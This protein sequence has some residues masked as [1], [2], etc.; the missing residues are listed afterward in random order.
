L[1]PQPLF[2]C[3]ICIGIQVF[4]QP[5][6]IELDPF[7]YSTNDASVEQFGFEKTEFAGGHGFLFVEGVWIEPPYVIERRGLDVFVNDVC[8]HAGS[9]LPF[10]DLRVTEDP[11]PPPD[12][13]PPW[14]PWV[15]R[16]AY[17]HECYWS[18]KSR[19]LMG[20]LTEKEFPEAMKAAYLAS[21]FVVSVSYSP[22]RQMYE[23]FPEEGRTRKIIQRYLPPPPP[24]ESRSYLKA[25][26]EYQEMQGIASVMVPVLHMRSKSGGILKSS[27]ES[28]LERLAVLAVDVEPEERLKLL[29]EKTGRKEL[30]YGMINTWTME[31]KPTEAFRVRVQAAEQAYLDH[32]SQKETQAKEQR[33]IKREQRIA[34]RQEAKEARH[35]ELLEAPPPVPPPVPEDPTSVRSPTN[36]SLYVLLSA[37]L[38]LLAVGGLIF[39]RTA[40]KERG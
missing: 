24:M 1:R 9:I 25:M 32:K 40:K 36:M 23:L 29:S 34:E 35:K 26:E 19:Y 7:N 39:F 15:G 28:A 5:A 22:D 8:I 14:A 33:R 38:V 27:L 13:L 16:V 12:D 2:L 10:V 4:A 18:R 30:P 21:P 17:Y 37:A 6:R 31:F 20:T 3:L 11:G